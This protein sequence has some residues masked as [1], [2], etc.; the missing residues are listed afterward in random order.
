MV[1]E[2]PASLYAGRSGQA[3]DEPSRARRM[4][5]GVRSRQRVSRGSASRAIAQYEQ[6][7]E[8]IEAKTRLLRSAA[9]G[10]VQAIMQA[11]KFP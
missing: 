10:H 8:G 6:Q 11:G 1:L 3:G 9:M 7:E 4:T 5:S 2:P